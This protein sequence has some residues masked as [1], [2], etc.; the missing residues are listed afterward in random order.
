MTDANLSFLALCVLPIFFLI[1]LKLIV[2]PRPIKIPI[3]SRHVFITGGSSGIGLALAR[4]AAAEGARVTILARDLN[5]LE[6]AKNS[7]RLSTGI[8]VNIVS[9]DVCDFQAVKEAVE[10]AGPIDV[11]VC[12][13]G[14][15]VAQEIV[16]QDVKEIRGMIDVNLIGTIN[17]VRAALPG[18]KNR[19]DRKP[20]SIAFMSSQAGQVG[21]YGYA[22][23]SASK[24]GLRGLAEA[25]QQ[26]VIADDIHV[27][28]IYPP[29]T[30]TPGLA[31]ARKTMSRLTSIITASSS[32]MEADE[33]AKKAL[34]GIKSGCFS[35]T[36][37][38]VGLLLSIATSGLSPQRSY[39]MAF[40]E[41]ITVG[42]VR[43]VAL[44][45]QW[46]WY[47]AI[48]KWHAH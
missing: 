41:V 28:L 20:V 11:L 12:N 8:D 38:L 31:K 14:V 10:N 45:F 44:C 19:S 18:M 42:A 15:F 36:C 26:E 9:V 22:A 25:L 1:F 29:E 43:I 16:N 40:V 33:V 2:R 23:Y 46:S 4:Q 34:N 39:L 24:F 27:S 37:N 3:K 30:K 13:Q 48:E 6:K 21:I 35:I 32:E 7:I 17:L 5:K 47:R